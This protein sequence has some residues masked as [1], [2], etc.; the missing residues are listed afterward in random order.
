MP[1]T[2]RSGRTRAA[3]KEGAETSTRP[4]GGA[5]PGQARREPRATIGAASDKKPG[6]CQHRQERI[7]SHDPQ[8]ELRRELLRWG[9]CRTFVFQFSVMSRRATSALPK[10]A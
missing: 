8:A 7:T 3:I 10:R 1:N 2:A 4:V 9:I 5:A 6:S